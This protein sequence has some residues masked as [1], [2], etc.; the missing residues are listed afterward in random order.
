MKL[1]DREL[2][3]VD[4]KSVQPKHQSIKTFTIYT[5]QIKKY[6]IHTKLKEFNNQSRNMCLIQLEN[7]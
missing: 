3:F 5:K 7:M 6:N 4:L 1:N 2:Q